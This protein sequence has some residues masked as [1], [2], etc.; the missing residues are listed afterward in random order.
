MAWISLQ[1][2]G[3]IEEPRPVIICCPGAPPPLGDSG[4]GNSGANIRTQPPR[5]L[6]LT[7]APVVFQPARVT[8][9]PAREPD[10]LEISDSRDPGQGGETGKGKPGDWSGVEDGTG[11]KPVKE[12]GT[13]EILYDIP[14]TPGLVSPVLVSRVEPLYPETARKLHLEGVAVLQ[15]VID[16]S[17][18]VVD[19]RVVKSASELLDAAAIAAVEKWIYRPATLNGRTVNVY[20]TVSVDFKLH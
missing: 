18:R 2:V 20:L 4:H 6:R 16:R 9:T 19:L 7:P 14:N 3:E 13:Q 1:T 10:S 5:P 8:D 11:N 17:G 12:I 15:A